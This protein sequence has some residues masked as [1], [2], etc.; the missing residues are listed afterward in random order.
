MWKIY[1]EIIDTIPE[2]LTVLECMRGVNWTLVRSERGTGM[3]MTVRG[4]KRSTELGSIGGMQLKELASSIKSWN[5]LEA[6]LGLA[7]I[8][9]ALN[10]SSVVTN[11]TDQLDD[12]S[13]DPE[14]FNGFKHLAPEISGKKVTVVGHFPEIEKFQ[15]ICELSILERKPQG[16]DYPDPACE[17]ILPEQ[18]FVFITG[19]AFINKTMPRLLELSKNATTIL[20]GPSVPI[21]RVVFTYGVSWL[22]SFVVFEPQSIW[23]AVQ[24]GE[25][26]NI[27]ARGGKMV[28]IH[29]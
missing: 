15:D 5:M 4:G 14:E 3:A 22:A 29:S 21:S 10:V 8:N 25:R 16:D 27:F 12:P 26:L 23:R 19:T 1:D 13:I 7:A 17:Y 18:D 24:E 9:A 6:S 11:I 28:C 2:E 20:I